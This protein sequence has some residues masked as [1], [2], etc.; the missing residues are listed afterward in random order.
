[1]SGP[2]A[3]AGSSTTGPAALPT[4]G[5]TA[6]LRQALGNIPMPGAKAPPKRPAV[7][8][9]VIPHKPSAGELRGGGGAGDGTEHVR[10]QKHKTKLKPRGRKP[11][12]TRQLLSS[13]PE[14]ELVVDDGAL[15]SEVIERTPLVEVVHEPTTPLRGHLTTAGCWGLYTG[16]RG[17][18]DK[19][20]FA[21]NNYAELRRCAG[22]RPIGEE[23]AEPRVVR[24]KVDEA[25]RREHQRGQPTLRILD[26]LQAQCERPEI[27]ESGPRAA[28]TLRVLIVGAGIGGLRLALELAAMNVRVAIIEKYR[29]FSRNNVLHMWEQLRMDATAWGAS[30]W[31]GNFC[32]GRIRHCPIRKL[33]LALLRSALLMGVDVFIGAEWKGVVRRGSK[34]YSE[35]DHSVL[36]NYDFNVLIGADG[37]HSHVAAYTGFKKRLQSYPLA[38]GV[39]ANFMND[40]TESQAKAEEINVARQFQPAFF[41]KIKASMGIELENLVYYK[42]DTHYIVCT[43]TKQSLIALGV[44]KEDKP[45]ICERGNVNRAM[46]EK[47]CMDLTAREACN[48]G[49]RVVP[50]QVTGAV[51]L[52][53][54]PPSVLTLV[55]G[56]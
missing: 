36:A 18:E 53:H 4:K 52:L 11:A 8:E 48:L 31:N 6:A 7:V 2:G 39:T 9:G 44:L 29:E 1:M 26:L 45:D 10:G 14:E 13:A 28:Q 56:R 12:D 15:F 33:Q 51:S 20:E 41:Q 19:V 46:L 37:E 38:I 21:L 35:T 43:V 22:L 40:A 54:L 23:T 3:D 49:S 17:A 27:V 55:P 24:M 16:N 47:M 50:V 32:N 42:D 25:V 5:K 34:W 30:Y